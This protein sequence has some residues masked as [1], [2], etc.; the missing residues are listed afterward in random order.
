MF[1]LGFFSVLTQVTFMREM[2]VAFFGN[3]L[4]IGTILASWLVGISLGAFSARFL[5]GR[6][7][8]AFRIECFLTALLIVLS[9]VLPLQVYV[10]RTIRLLLHVPVGEYT[11]FGALLVS[12]L[13]AFFP[14]C[15]SIGLF[16]PSAC[17]LLAGV[18]SSRFRVHGSGAEM[19]SCSPVSLI[20]TFEAMGGMLGGAML[21]FVL[22]PVMSPFRIVL[23]ADCIALVGAV[24]IAPRRIVRG[25]LLSLAVCM[26]LGALLYPGWLRSIEDW[27]IK[28]RWHAFGILRPRQT[29]LSPEVRLL[30]SD[31]SI[32]QNLAVTE[33][34]GQFAL[35]GN[36]QVI[37]VFPD[38]IGYEHS[39]H[40]IMAQKPL[41]KRVLLLGGNPV[42]DIPELLKYPIERLVY[43]ELDPG[44][45]RMIRKVMGREYDGILSEGSCGADR[46][47][48]CVLQDAPHF[49]QRC[50]EKFDVVL[51]NAPEPTTTGAN[52]FYTLEF[53]KNIRRIL[54]E[55][56]FMYTA[57]TSSERLQS[58]AVDLGASVYQTLRAVFPVVLVTAEARN[59]FFA[60][61]PEAG[62]TFDRTTLYTRSKNANLDA[63]FFRPE[64][65]LGADEITP[66]KT[67][68]VEKRFSTRAVPLNTN[69][70][71]I[72]YFYNLLLWSRFSGSGIE[73]VLGSMK[74]SSSRELVKRLV[75][76][77][78]ICVM[79]GATL[80]IRRRKPTPSPSPEGSH[81]GE[82]RRGELKEFPSSDGLGVGRIEGVWSRLMIGVL[83]AT[84]GFCGMALEILLIFV[85]QSLY[86]YVYIRMGLIV[87][88]FMLGLVLGAPS[89]RI[90]AGGRWWC[91]WLAMAGVELLLVIFPLTVPK[92]IRMASLPIGAD[93]LLLWYEVG[94]YLAV[95]FIGWA[96]GAEF[97]I[98]NRLFCDAGGTVGTAAAITDA[99]DHIGAAIGCLVMGV[100]LIP[101]LGIEASCV[102]LAALKC[103]GLLLLASALLGLHKKMK[104][105]LPLADSNFPTTNNK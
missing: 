25:V 21:T 20:Y 84:T 46:R 95:V 33:S 81:S 11:P 55:D 41:A 60:G 101:I 50:R 18:Q 71:P 29:A 102:V 49:A 64:Y 16:F 39:I 40:F 56:G 104:T 82:I 76:A 48:T 47:V 91:S 7:F 3:E 57:V 78:A 92:L 99:S 85:F 103:A 32:Y 23:L 45:G 24:I 69:L 36:G 51:V 62:L 94:I 31:N 53:Y 100:I 37:F 19:Q 26:A 93:Q 14:A 87:A 17:E 10:I 83:I 12:A 67:K 6:F 52:R 27:T 96:V 22:L 89:G 34:E 9:V 65:F 8:S 79:V 43:V 88:M 35:Y 61:K 86:G 58:E 44:V 42:G 68:Y 73:R 13:L 15:Y 105:Y 4:S 70:R 72:T 80:R 28:A 54:A 1:C 38:A 75:L 59:R 66:E 2:L 74:S 90:M 63:K 77:G 97:P 98:A 30:Y 5:L